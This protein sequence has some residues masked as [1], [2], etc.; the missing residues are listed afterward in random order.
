[1]KYQKFTPPGCKD[2][3]I[4][5]FKFVAKTQFLYGNRLGLFGHRIFGII[6]E[7]NTSNA[8]CVEFC[9][10]PIIPYTSNLNTSL[11]IDTPRWSKGSVVNR[12]LPLC[13]GW[14]KITLTVLFNYLQLLYREVKGILLYQAGIPRTILSY[15]AALRMFSRQ[16]WSREPVVK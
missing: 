11:E 6:E 9:P 7:Y 14:P 13:K 4:I 2:I 5:I 16:N 1:M 12:T 8:S 15:L 10:D 3:G